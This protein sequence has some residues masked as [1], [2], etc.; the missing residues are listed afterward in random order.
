MIPYGQVSSYGRIADLAGFPRRA[1]Q[2]SKSLQHASQ[3]GLT[4]IPWHRVVNSQGKI[5]FPQQHPLYL[6][7][8]ALLKQEGISV[9]HGKVKL[10]QYLWQADIATLVLSLPY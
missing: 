9:N 10:S 2:V 7:Q 8:I 3:N 4:D 6:K 1:R 5:A